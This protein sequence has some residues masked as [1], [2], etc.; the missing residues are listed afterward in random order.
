MI[1]SWLRSRASRRALTSARQ[2]LAI[3]GVPTEGL[4]D[5]E[6]LRRS[7]ELNRR[8][9]EEWREIEEMALRAD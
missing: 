9:A 5:E 1:L 6:I 3:F 7:E 2:A 4:S 8:I